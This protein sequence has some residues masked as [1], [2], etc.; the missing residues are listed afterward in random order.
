MSNEYKLVPTVP[1]EAMMAAGIAASVEGDVVYA[2]P[3]AEEWNKFGKRVNRVSHIYN[4]MLAA[5]PAHDGEVIYQ[6]RITDSS[7]WH[8]CSKER[9]NKGKDVKGIELRTLYTAPPR[10]V[11]LLSLL[12]KWEARAEKIGDYTQERTAASSAIRDCADE[13]QA[14]LEKTD[15]S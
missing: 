1:T 4:A 15:A 8:T 6:Y 12:T 5:S 9:F 3:S 11:D 10:V 14:A 13:L 7:N 2:T